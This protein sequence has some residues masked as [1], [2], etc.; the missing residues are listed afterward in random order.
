MSWNG[1]LK[2]NSRL[3]QEE[4]E[5]YIASKTSLNKKQ[6][7]ECFKVY[8]EIIKQIYSDNNIDKSM[9]I[10]LPYIGKFYLIKQTGRKDGTRYLLP[11]LYGGKGVW[12][13][14][15]NE[16]SYYKLKFK[17]FNNMAECIKKGT[18]FIEK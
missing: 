8:A 4:I 5:S 3:C 12:K 14:A 18:S 7:K 2:D 15:K 16:P 6:V 10:P 9:T 13:I 11:D 17:I 1:K